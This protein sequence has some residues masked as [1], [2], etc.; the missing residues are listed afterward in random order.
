MKYVVSNC[1]IS[2]IRAA[3]V[4][5]LAANGLSGNPFDDFE[6][7]Q[8]T[9]NPAQGGFEYSWTG[10]PDH[11]YFVEMSPDL[12]PGSWSFFPYATKGVGSEAGIFISLSAEK[13]FYRLRYTD[14]VNSPLLTADF[15][16][17]GFSNR[18]QLD[19]ETDPFET[20]D[21]DQNG[22]PDAIE[23][24]WAQVPQAWK[25]AIVNDPNADFYDPDDQ[26]G[27][28]ADILPGDDYDGDRRSNLREYLD[29]TDPADFFNGDTPQLFIVRGNFQKSTPESITNEPMVVLVLN[30]EGGVLANA[31]VVFSVT[32]GGGQLTRSEYSPQHA[33]NYILRTNHL[34]RSP[35]I[36]FKQPNQ[37]GINSLIT[38]TAGSAAVSF[39]FY[40]IAQA[41]TEVPPVATNVTEIENPDSSITYTWDHAGGSDYFKFHHKCSDGFWYPVGVASGSQRSYTINADV[42]NSLQ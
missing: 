29:G 25:L 12:S 17:N 31:P 21:A 36:C 1:L 15:N 28:S 18:D 41:S 39:E 34:G 3:A 14:D 38:A 35:P 24:F 23:A 7:I 33:Q 13:F 37:S 10:Q 32:A 16:A 11:Y 26:I 6:D 4:C 5:L 8:W 40:S 9:Y 22:I 20:T 2:G 42:I 30:S 27:S 19:I